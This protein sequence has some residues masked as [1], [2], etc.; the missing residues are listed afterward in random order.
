M[1]TGAFRRP[2][3][4]VILGYAD[5]CRKTTVISIP[6]KAPVGKA[7]RATF[8]I[9]LKTNGRS[10]TQVRAVTLSVGR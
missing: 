7:V 2:A 1:L 5:R 6:V 9:V 3:G 4:R 8:K 10:T